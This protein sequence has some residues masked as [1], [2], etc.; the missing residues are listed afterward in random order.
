MECVLIDF[1][2]IQ[3]LLLQHDWERGGGLCDHVMSTMMSTFNV[4]NVF[5]WDLKTMW[6]MATCTI[7]NHLALLPLFHIMCETYAKR[8]NIW[9]WHVYVVFRNSIDTLSHQNERYIVLSF[10]VYCTIT[11]S[12]IVCVCSCGPRE[13]N[14]GMLQLVQIQN[15]KGST[16]CNCRRN[17]MV[18][19]LPNTIHLAN[20]YEGL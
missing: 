17:K 20:E 10:H 1:L 2:I 14:L 16:C 8:K 12:S 6:Q 13:Y 19:I 4:Q 7:W 9:I 11:L 5:T 18:F 3:D 15:M